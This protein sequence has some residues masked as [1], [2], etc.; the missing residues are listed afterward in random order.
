[1]NMWNKNIVKLDWFT[2]ALVAS[3]LTVKPGSFCILCIRVISLYSFIR[4]LVRI[5]VS[6]D[7]GANFLLVLGDIAL[8]NTKIHCY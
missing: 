7:F 2:V 5:N 6:S 3:M 8:Q 4:R 1:M